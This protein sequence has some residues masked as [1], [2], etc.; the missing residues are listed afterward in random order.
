[1]QPIMLKTLLVPTSLAMLTLLTSMGSPAGAA[2]YQGFTEPYRSADVSSP[3]AG[4]ITQLHVREGQSVKAGTLLFELDTAVL[5][6][7][8]AIAKARFEAK[9]PIAAAHS[10]LKLHRTRLDKLNRLKAKGHARAD[11]LARARADVATASAELRVAQEQRSIA[12]LELAQSELRLQRRRVTSPFDGIVSELHREVSEIV[13][14]SNPEILT[15]VQL[16]TLKV[17]LHLP[18]LVAHKLSKGQAIN[19]TFAETG[20]TAPAKVEVVSPV[21]DADSGTTRVT[22]VV[23]NTKGLYRAGTRCTV[24]L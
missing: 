23:D 15:L 16:E 22:F 3:E 18:S 12:G 24:D 21:T 11:E 13:R 10:K 19:L 4:V 6:S 1:M 7:A 2:E 5:E 17:I 8:V 20:E 9:G 14:T